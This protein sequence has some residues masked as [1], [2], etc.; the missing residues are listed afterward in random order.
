M[1]QIKSGVNI[2]LFSI[3][4]TVAPIATY[5]QY[6]VDSLNNRLQT[7][8]T[9]TSKFYSLCDLAFYYAFAYIDSSRYYT[10]LATDLAEKMGFDYGVFYAYHGLFYS[11]ITQG[12]YPKA[13]EIAL[14][15]LLQEQKLSFL[16]SWLLP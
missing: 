9:D 10:K 5:A 12:N 8:K 1:K 14:S 16:K 7:A 11:F 2:F 6:F 4:F 13:I 15:K 3:L